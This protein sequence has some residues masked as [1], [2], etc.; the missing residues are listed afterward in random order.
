MESVTASGGAARQKT[1]GAPVQL[2]GTGLHTGT[3]VRMALRPAEPDSGIVFRRS[4]SPHG[5]TIP[6]TWENVADSRLCT[7]IANESGIRVGT[8]EHLM[9]AFSGCEV[10]NV[11]VELNGPE[12]PAMDGSAAPF[13]TLIERAGVV[14]QDRL[15]RGIEVLKTVEV[16][17]GSAR[18][19]LSPAPRFT[20]SCEI[21][22]DNPAV[23]R[24][25][26]TVELVNGTF[27]SEICRARTFGF[28]SDVLELR[29]AGYARGGSLENAVVIGADRVLNRGGLRYRDEFV[30]HK[31]LDSI[32][33]LYLA[34]GPIV[35]HFRGHRSGHRMNRELLQALFADRSAWRFCTVPEDGEAT[36]LPAPAI[37]ARA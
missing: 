36:G 26:C 12:V 33:D 14:A 24:Q 20:V 18:A 30:R 2:S 21:E 35:G 1:V 19:S 10:D 16:A 6:A 5:P 11:L 9:A 22:Y 15:R 34:G 8:I 27:K 32:G 25:A 17:D 23:Q 4:D 7:A 13:V 37:R 29:A 3:R 28:E 31:I